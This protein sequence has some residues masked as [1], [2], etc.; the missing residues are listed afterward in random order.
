[1]CPV[2]VHEILEAELG[3]AVEEFAEFDDRPM[4]AASIGQVHHA[5]LRDG[6]HVAVKI[7]YPGVAALSAMIWPTPSCW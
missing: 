4:A 3:C 2:L 7:Q 1:M 5:V 6:R